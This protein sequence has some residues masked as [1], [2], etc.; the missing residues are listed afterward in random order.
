MAKQKYYV[1][2]KG[3]K[4]GVFNSWEMCSAQVSGFAGAEYKAFDNLPTAESAFRSAYK[5]YVGK[6]TV[7]RDGS[8]VLY[9]TTPA[10]FMG[11]WKTALIKPN[12]PSISVDAACAGVPGPV[13]WRGVETESQKELFRFG[14]FPDGTN[15]IGEFLAVVRGL[16]WLKEKNLNWPLYSDSKN[17]ILWVKLKKC[18]T[19]ME[20]TARNKP[21]FDLIDEAE[22]W[23]EEHKYLNKVLKW[24][25]DDWGENPADFGR[26]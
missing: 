10:N 26:K 1:V 16:S 12:L 15:N 9:S 18:R 8:E 4:T 21:L 25:T 5:D 13:E 14:P 2:W 11:K 3:R 7:T 19:K 6:A 17:A 20:H 24:E 22:A 23:L